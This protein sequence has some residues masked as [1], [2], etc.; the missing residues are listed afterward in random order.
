MHSNGPLS[1]VKARLP[2][3]YSYAWACY[4]QPNTL[5]GDEFDLTST[6]GVQQGD[7]CRPVLFAVALQRIIL[8]QKEFFLRFQVW[9]LDDGHL[10]GTVDNVGRAMEQLKQSLPCLD[11]EL[12]LQKCK[13]FGLNA[14]TASHPGLDGIPRVSFDDGIVVLGTPIGSDACSQFSC[15]LGEQ[16]GVVADQGAEA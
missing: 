7:V 16:I 11:L 13:D 15:Q 10:C 14:P 6:R 12:N 1:E 2:S 3:L 5:F 4:H 8:Q 9:F